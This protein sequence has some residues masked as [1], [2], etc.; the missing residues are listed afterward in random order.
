MR[1]N[2]CA[3]VL[4]RVLQARERERERD[5]CCGRSF[6]SAMITISG[7]SLDARLK[8]NLGILACAHTHT[9]TYTHTYRWCRCTRQGERLASCSMPAMVSHILFPFMVGA[10]CDLCSCAH[11]SNTS[12]R[13]ASLYLSIYLYIYI[14][15]ID[16]EI[17]KR[18]SLQHAIILI[19][20]YNI[21]KKGMIISKWIYVC[22]CDCIYIY[23]LYIYIY[24]NP[25]M[26]R[27]VRAA[28]CD[29]AP[30]SCGPRP[31]RIHVQAPQWKRL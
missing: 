19:Y 31:H 29:Y 12:T 15:N 30:G 13:N 20:M 23:T 25:C 16:I 2:V 8:L 5:V 3:R 28:T 22:V 27:G 18:Y 7:S 10:S 9:H 4:A 1:T 11:T 6:V 14:Y 26:Y 17:Y 24:L 21:K